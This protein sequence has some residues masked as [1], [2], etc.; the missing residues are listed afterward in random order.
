MKKRDTL[1]YILAVLFVVTIV[2]TLLGVTKV[3]EIDEF[4]LKGLFGAFLI[5]LA[6]AVFNIVKNGDLLAETPDHTVNAMPNELS[7]R[8]WFDAI[9]KKLSDC[10]YAR[11]YLRSFD[12]P[13]DFRGE[14]KEK[15]NEIIST[16]LEKI[17]SG[18][19][20]KIISFLPVSK[21]KT[22]LDWIHNYVDGSIDL[23]RYIKVVKTQPVSNSSSMYL[24][25]DRSVIYNKSSEGKTTYHIENYAN[26]IIHELIAL[27]FDELEGSE[28]RECLEELK[29]A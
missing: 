22:G 20:I 1:F 11:L 28:E 15:L 26:S 3:I 24:F 21:N 13:D 2:I 23:R 27:G 10:G 14:H 8:E 6:A 16:I 9:A 7:S 19:N 18:A 4:Y 12:H 17:K 5:E 29:E 25:D